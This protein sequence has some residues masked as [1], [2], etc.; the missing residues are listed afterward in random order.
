MQAGQ[1]QLALCGGDAFVQLRMRNQLPVGA[2]DEVVFVAGARLSGRCQQAVYGDVVADRA[3]PFAVPVEWLN[4]RNHPGGGLFVEINRGPEKRAFAV[5]DRS[6]TGHRRVVEVVSLRR[7]GGTPVDAARI[8]H[9]ADFD[10]IH[11]HR[12]EGRYQRRPL[13]AEQFVTGHGAPAHRVVGFAVCLVQVE[14]RC[15]FGVDLV[16]VQAPQAI[17]AA[18]EEFVEALAALRRIQRIQALQQFLVQALHAG[19]GLAEGFLMRQRM[20]LGQLLQ[21]QRDGFFGCQ[22]Q[23]DEARAGQQDQQHQD[24]CAQRKRQAAGNGID[25]ASG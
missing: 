12:E 5:V 21:G 9:Q 11:V 22:A 13:F 1:R 6:C 16:R 24:Q 7:R 23:G 14:G 17:G 3:D 15:P 8:D 18:R 2:Q 19:L 20:R 4:R 25:H 10:E